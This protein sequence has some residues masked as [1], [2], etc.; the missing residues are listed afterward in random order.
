MKKLYALITILSLSFIETEKGFAQNLY[1]IAGGGNCGSSSCGDGAAATAAQLYETSGIV[2]DGAGNIYIADTGNDKIRKINSAGI[3]TTFA[4]NGTG[5][6]TGDGAQATAAELNNPIAMVFDAT[7]NMYIADFFNNRIR[8]IDL[9]GIITTIAGNGTGGFNGDGGQASAAE[10]YHPKWVSLDATGNVYI[11]DQQN[12]SVRKISTTGVIST[13]A[14]NQTLGFSGDGGQATAAQ[15]SGLSGVVVDGAG[16]LYIPDGTNNRIRKVSTAGIITTIAGNGTGGFSGDGGQA[17]AAELNGPNGVVLDAAGNLYVADQSN[18]SIRKVSTSGII[19]TVIGNGTGGFSG[20]GGSATAAE[21]RVPSSVTI[22]AANNLYVT[23]LGNNR[24]RMT[25]LPFTLT[26]SSATLCAGATSTLTASG[27]ANYN[28]LPAQSLNATTGI[29]V[30]ASPST[31]T[32]YS[33]SRILYGI[34]AGTDTSRIMVNQ[35]PVVSGTSYTNVTCNGGSN[36]VASVS[37]TAG[38]RPY[39]YFWT[40]GNNTDSIATNLSSN[41]YH[42]V[43]TDNNSC[44]AVAS[45]NVSA[46]APITSFVTSHKNASC[47]GSSNGSIK[48]TIAGG[49]SATYTISWLPSG[50]SADSVSGLA[51]GIYTCNIMDSK[52]CTGSATYTITQP[53]VIAVSQSVAVCKGQSITVGTSTYSTVGTYT[54]VLIA[55]NTCDSTV[56]T[57]LTVNPLPVMAIG[58]SSPTICAGQTATLTVSGA[59]TYTWSTSQDVSTIMVSPTTSSDYTVTGTDGNNCSNISIAYVDVNCALGIGTEANGSYKITIYPNPSAGNFVLESNA[60]GDAFM[61]VFDVTGKLVLSQT[62]QN[63][64]VI[65]ASVLP[66]GIYNISVTGTQLVTNKRLLIVK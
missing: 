24:V 15:L 59:T 41:S 49:N 66:A 11:A 21:L 60:S 38:A 62:V 48:T 17:T 51:A 9:S 63:K 22:D 40:P 46:P 32:T 42:C 7:G 14:G 27:S 25:R 54:N 12:Y 16:N 65:D 4:G 45:V 56:A 47:N 8:K 36:G 52:S 29:S 64:S 43:I 33:I 37:V 5:G 39:A 19:T 3:I 1:T 20:D 31:T 10:L 2:V 23:D 57:N 58:I 30:V 34:S 13:V 28:W 18:S 44:V 26:T 61:Q 35:V 6:F 55:K 53:A 50:G